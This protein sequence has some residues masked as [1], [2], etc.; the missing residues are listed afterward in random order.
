MIVITLIT[1]LVL[2]DPK[3]AVIISVSL[4]GSYLLI[5]LFLRLFLTRIGKERLKSNKLRFLAISQAFGAA[6]EV[7]VG[8][9]EQTY[10]KRFSA[11]AQSYAKT[12]ASAQ[13]VRQLP[14]YFFRSNCF[15]RNFNSNTLLD[16]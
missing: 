3:L 8:G 11:P 4:G 9:L 14:R 16:D 6:K 12:S 5:F 7:K 10:I 2:T 13:V 15:W 1:L